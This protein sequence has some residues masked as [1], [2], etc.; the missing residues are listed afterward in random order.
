L[1]NHSE[2]V[3]IEYD[4]ARISYGDLLDVFWYSHNPA[5][6]Q[7]SSQY[8]SVIFYHNDEQKRQAIESRDRLEAETDRK[9]YTEIVRAPTF[10]IAEDYHQKYYLQQLRELADEF[11][12][13]YPEF[14]DYVNSTAVARVNGYAGG[15]GTKETLHKELESLGLSPEGIDRV[16][17]IAERGLAPACPA[18][19]TA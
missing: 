6:P 9:I 17:A 5:F 3:Q 8:K 13:I 11:M 16:L 19:G 10:Y 14:N 12:A 18:P 1:G 2:T 15:Y 4:P 7:W